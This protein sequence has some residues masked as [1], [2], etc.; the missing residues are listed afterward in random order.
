MVVVVVVGLFHIYLKYKYFYND[1]CIEMVMIITN[2][3]SNLVVWLKMHV[4]EF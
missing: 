2:M 1:K 3:S 4:I